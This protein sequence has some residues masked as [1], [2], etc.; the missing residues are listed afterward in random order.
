MEVP[1]LDTCR[2][3][4]LGI[5]EDQLNW[6]MHLCQ[7]PC[8]SLTYPAISVQCE[9]SAIEIHVQS[10][11]CLHNRKSFPFSL[12]VLHLSWLALSEAWWCRWNLGRSLTWKLLD[13]PLQRQRMAGQTTFAK[14]TSPK[15]VRDCLVAVKLKET[16][17]L[18]P[19]PLPDFISQPG[20]KLGEGLEPI[21]R[22]GPEMVDSI[23]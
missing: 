23:L 5:V 22:H 19:R 9:M 21:L 13:A 4:G 10:F 1:S 6:F 20:E 17:S 7:I 12:G 16:S 11:D 15:N 14:N 2:W 18:V 8:V 3:S